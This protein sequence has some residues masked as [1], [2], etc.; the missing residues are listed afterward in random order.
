MEQEHDDYGEPGQVPPPAWNTER[1]VIMLF[2]V[3]Y[4]A[5]LLLILAM[6]FTGRM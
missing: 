5:L 2:R 4:V 3:V 6:L 1:I